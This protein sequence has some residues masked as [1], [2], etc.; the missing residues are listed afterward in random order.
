MATDLGVSASALSLI[1]KGEHRFT[2]RIASAASETYRVPV[3]FFA[4]PVD[5]EDLGPLTFKKKSTARVR[6]EKRVGRLYG[7]AA[8]LFRHASV[9]SG[10]Q[11]A[12]LPDPADFDHDP[13]ALA[14]EVRRRVKL[15]PEEHV[16]NVVRLCERLGVGVVDD[17]DTEKHEE[18]RHSGVSRPNRHSTRPL[19]AVVA[20]LD[21]ALKRF[22]VAHEL[23]HLIADRDLER[24]LTSTRDPRE[25]A[26]NRFAGALLLPEP[27]AREYLH[28]GLTL[29]GFLRI[30]ADF[31]IEV[32]G[33][34]H[35]AHD[36]GIIDGDRARSLYI[37][38]SSSGWRTHEPVE[39]PNER[40]LLLG[41]ALHK[42]HGRNYAAR[43]SHEIGVPAEL[44]AHWTATEA[45]S[46]SPDWPNNVVSLTDRRRS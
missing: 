41:Q 14:L 20:D 40:P 35:R 43:V 26:A 21:P 28:S 46:P 30:K 5:P 44:V 10:Y 38:W 33:L 37:Q 3:E 25:Q 27:A 16:G 7:E 31:G 18:P 29:H 17:L 15:S 13:E 2:E 32:R 23:H 11:P 19:I 12:D 34:I 1:V 6:D 4:V 45:A 42:A 24:P 36:L 39:I 8:R 22:T 9:A